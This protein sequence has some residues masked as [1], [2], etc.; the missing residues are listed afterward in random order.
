M[1]DTEK[2]FRAVEN[3]I[4]KG[5]YFTI[6]RARQ[7]GKTTTI[8]ALSKAL[9]H[10][11]EVVSLSFEGIGKAGVIVSAKANIESLTGESYIGVLSSQLGYVGL[12]I[13]LFFIIFV[14]FDLFKKYQ[15]S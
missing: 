6:N 3:L 11:Y 10:E 14:V 13:Y 5:R 12:V 15:I 7:Y 2:R 8:D 1:V 9:K 4:D